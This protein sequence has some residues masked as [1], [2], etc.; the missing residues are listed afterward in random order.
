MERRK[1]LYI[2]IKTLDSEDYVTGFGK[3]ELAVTALSVAIAL[4]AGLIVAMTANSL[5]GILVGCFIVATVFVV[6]RRDNNNE[7]M[8]KKIKI[9]LQCNKSQKRYLYNHGTTFDYSQEDDYGGE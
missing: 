8:A 4:V 9:V 5:V 1:P 6:V 7:N 3:M 2:P